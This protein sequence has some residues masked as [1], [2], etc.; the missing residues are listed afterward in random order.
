MDMSNGTRMSK[1]RNEKIETTAQCKEYSVNNKKLIEKHE[2]I[3]VT[4][5]EESFPQL[6]GEDIRNL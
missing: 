5:D 4:R 1:R 2:F 3:E 6:Q